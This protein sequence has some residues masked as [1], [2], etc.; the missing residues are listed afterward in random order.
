MSS[1]PFQRGTFAGLLDSNRLK[2]AVPD[3]SRLLVAVSGGAD[4]VALLRGLKE[5]SGRYGV[6]CVHVN[7]GLRPEA[8]ADEEF[9][10]GL[11]G[12]LGVRYYARRLADAGRVIDG[13]PEGHWRRLRYEAFAN[14]MT[15]V[16][17]EALVLGHTADDLAETF[18]FHLVRG[19]GVEGLVFDFEGEAG[20]LRIL[21]PLWKTRRARIEQVLR[22]RGQAWVEDAT[23]LDVRFSRNLIRQRVMPLLE[24]INPEAGAAIVRASESLGELLAAR[25]VELSG[26]AGDKEFTGECGRIWTRDFKESVRSEGE[27][28]DRLRKFVVANGGTLDSSQTAQA[29]H[30]VSSGKG[31]LVS[32]A[33]GRT[34]V[35]SQDCVWLCGRREPDEKA[36]AVEHVERFGGIYADLAEPVQVKADGTGGEGFEIEL[37]DGQLLRGWLKRDG[38]QIFQ[39]RNRK[40]GESVGGT[41]LKK[42]LNEQRIPWYL[43]SFLVLVEGVGG[44]ICGV[45]SEDQELV[46]AFRRKCRVGVEFGF[47]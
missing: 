13:S 40:P 9:V 5:S 34:L 26:R 38:G 7:H 10:R 31:G 14:V 4:S 27:L 11:C 42:V 15:E 33:G 19:T 18:L 24:K 25:E 36:V 23:N 17:A 37:L 1:A 22:G 41:P 45:I 39:L 30:L 2:R 12:D 8:E 35:V 6:S 16:E 44:E 21:R 32:L 28:R 20:G 29:V 47:M 3:G 43:R 46:E